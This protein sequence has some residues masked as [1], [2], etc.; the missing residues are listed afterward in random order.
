MKSQRQTGFTI[1][2]LLIVIVV[3]GILAAITIVAYSGV[4]QRARVAT[5]TSDLS[6]VRKSLGAYEAINSQYPTALSAVNEGRGVKTSSGTNVQYTGSAATYCVT[7]TNGSISYKITDTAQTPAVGGCVGHTVGGG[8]TVIA[9]LMKNPS[10]ESSVAGWQ[11]HTL[12]NSSRTESGG[13]WSV[14]G[15]RNGTGSTAIYPGRGDT[16]EVTIGQTY[17][18]SALV[19]SS[20]AQ[21]VNIVVRNNTSSNPSFTQTSYAL[22]ANVPQRIHTTGVVTDSTVHVT[23]LW[24][25]GAIGDSVTVD[26]VMLVAGSTNYAYADGNTANWTWDGA[27]N[28]STSAGPAI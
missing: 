24:A 27:T 4:Q 19:T 7:A 8:A 5:V 11:F 6:N 23:I 28:L 26:E 12:V 15:T 25:G 16:S 2:E 3:I 1:V 14:T 21:T 17:T 18:A 20:T 22:A 13:K 10:V 9:N